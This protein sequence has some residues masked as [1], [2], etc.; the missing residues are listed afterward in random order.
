MLQLD[1]PFRLWIA[2]QNHT[3]LIWMILYLFFLPFPSAY[4]ANTDKGSDIS[5][6]ARRLLISLVSWNLLF[7]PQS[8]F[9]LILKG[10]GSLLSHLPTTFG[11]HFEVQ[12]F[13]CGIWINASLRHVSVR[14]LCIGTCFTF[15]SIDVPL[16]CPESRANV[17][18]WRVEFQSLLQYRHV[19]PLFE[20]LEE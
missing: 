19:L 2:T 4:E 8:L 1:H 12:I 7:E 10:F 9:I 5:F 14:L 16:F 18:D 17:C 11:V 3:H 13:K 6:P 20:N 15:P